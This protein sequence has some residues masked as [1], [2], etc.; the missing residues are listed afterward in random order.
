MAETSTAQNNG[1]WAALAAALALHVLVL[2]LPMTH[3]APPASGDK[4]IELDL[5]AFQ[6]ASPPLVAAVPEPVPVPQPRPPESTSPPVAAPEPP[7]PAEV[8]QGQA[9]EV[10]TRDPSDSKDVILSRQFISEESA[11][12]QLF[13]KPPSH[14]QPPAPREF[15][16]PH[17][18]DMLTMLHAPMPDLPFEYT[19]GLVHFAY[20]P[21]VRGDLQRFWDVITPEFG[22]RTNSGTE[23]R[24]VWLLVIV[25][26][27][28]K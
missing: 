11:A 18:P 21:G 28:W 4:R 8:E 2:L 26:C 20:A 16:F 7:I 13:G 24:C 12:D 27:G 17:K 15:H 1:I 25:G 19:P 3:R 6:P 5:I 9:V 23:V 10:V 22:W 14:E